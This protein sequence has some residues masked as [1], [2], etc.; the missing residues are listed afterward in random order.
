[1]HLPGGS[2]AAGDEEDTMYK[3]ILIPTDG[4]TLSE[5][6]AVQGVAFAKAIDAKVTGITVSPPFHTFALDPTT[7][8]DTPGQYE[9]DCATRAAT[10]L[11]VLEKA[12]R[13]AGVPYEGFHI[14]REHPYEAII[15]AAKGQGCDLIFM[16]SHG[17]KGMSALVLGSETVKVL[18]HSK[19]PVL[20]CR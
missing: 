13:I 12:A 19:V 8:T 10:Y 14:V 5:I 7:L 15:D 2:P 3:H 20:V 1:M 17:R 6:A 18:T 4:S 9:E 11:G 16:A